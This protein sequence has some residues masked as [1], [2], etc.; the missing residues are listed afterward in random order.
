MVRQQLGP[1][2]LALPGHYGYMTAMWSAIPAILLLLVWS[3]FE[4]SYLN[5]Q[6]LNNLPAEMSGASTEAMNLY[7]NNVLLAVAN[8]IDGAD[9]GIQH[10][11]N[12]Y[13][14]AQN[15]SRMIVT[16]LIFV[17]YHFYLIGEG[18]TTN[19]RVKKNDE[20]DYY[21]KELKA[22]GKW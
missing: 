8:G 18:Q 7:V 16:L 3:I 19:E 21:K 1:Y 6:I 2:R 11:A 12:A 20:I 13:V 4:S 9:A 5:Q 22:I 15:D 14:E 10:A 17:L